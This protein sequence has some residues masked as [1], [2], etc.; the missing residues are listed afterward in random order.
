MRRTVLDADPVKYSYAQPSLRRGG[1]RLHPIKD[2]VAPIG[3]TLTG[4]RRRD[5]AGNKLRDIVDPVTGFVMSVQSALESP[6][7]NC[8]GKPV[9]SGISGS[10]TRDTADGCHTRTEW[11]GRTVYVDDEGYVIRDL[12]M[13]EE[14][15][16]VSR[17]C[18]TPKPQKAKRRGKMGATSARP[19]VAG[20]SGP[21]GRITRSDCEAL[22]RVMAKGR[23]VQITPALLK[24]AKAR[25]I[26]LQAA[27]RR[28]GASG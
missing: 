19:P 9:E 20:G 11:K 15:I 24:A 22:I 28:A 21:N 8:V 14:S 13:G 3:E 5:R 23:N 17:V 4:M 2:G 18:A 10:H 25:I 16:P 1:V 27:A 26:E 6:A 7:V 12:S